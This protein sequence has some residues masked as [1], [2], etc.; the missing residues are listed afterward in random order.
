MDK[1]LVEVYIPVLNRSYDVYIPATTRLSEV[2]ALLASAVTELSDGY[3][4]VRPD[5]VLCDKSSGMLLDINKSA[6]ELGL[7]NGSRLMLI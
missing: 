5:T 2:E 3:F 7:Q 4:T 1:Y 6:L